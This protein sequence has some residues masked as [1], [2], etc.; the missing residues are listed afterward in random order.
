MIAATSLHL[1]GNLRFEG[2]DMIIVIDGESI[3]FP[4]AQISQR[5]L[6]ATATQREHFEIAASGYGIHWPELDEDLSIDGLL[7]S[8]AAK[9]Q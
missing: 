4:L 3:H 2:D 8:S 9:T 7:R 5:L 1:V 6:G